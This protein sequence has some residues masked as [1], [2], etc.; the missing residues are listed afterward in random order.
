MAQRVSSAT[1]TASA[2]LCTTLV[3]FATTLVLFADQS[4][5]VVAPAL[6]K[7]AGIPNPVGN[8]PAAIDAGKAMFNEV[9]SDCHG[10]DAVGDK[11]GP[12]LDTGGF[13]H[14]GDD[15]EIFRTIRTGVEGT[16]MEAH[17]EYSDEQTWQLVAYIKSLS[18]GS[19][20]RTFTQRY[21]LGCH[22]DRA[23]RG[24][25]T[26]QGLKLTD[27]PAHGHVWEKVLRQVQAGDM[28]P[29]RARVRPDPEAANRFASF[30]ESTLDRE[31]VARPNPGRVPAHR[32]NRAEYS[33]GI[34]D[35]LAL[36]VKPGEWLPVDDSGYG[37][38]NIAAV[39][40]T[41]PALLERYMSAARRISRMAIG[42]LTLRPAE[43]I[44]EARDGGGNRNEQ[45]NGDLPF[46]SRGGMTV[47]H[48]FPVDAEY[49]FA[50]RFNTDPNA[51]ADAYSVKT[52]L[53][54]GL[55]VVGATTRR[56]HLK[57]EAEAPAGRGPFGGGPPGGGPRE[58]RP[59][60]DLYI[61]RARVHRFEVSG[62]TSDPRQLLIRGPFNI[63]SHG[64]TPSRAQIFM[65][66]PTMAV[67]EVPCARRIVSS[68][69]RRAFRRPVT[70]ADVA[71]L[72]AFYQAARRSGDFDSGIE[73][74]L[75]AML[76]SPEFL[77]RI[78]RA[79][80]RGTAGRVAR[81]SD[82]DLASR[83]SFFL[84]SSI[85]DDEL[86]TLAERGRLKHPAVLKRQ[87]RRML[88][89]RRSEALVKNFAGQ[90]LQIRSVETV[91]PDPGIF[92]F[93][94]TLRRSFIEET[95]L[96]VDSVVRENRSLLDLLDADYTFLNQRLAEHY[97]VPKIYGSQFR[98]V[99]V[100]DANR[101]G[102]LGHG[103]VLTVTSYPN[104]TS[105]VQRG[106]WVLESLLG[107]PPPPPPPDVPD[108]KAAPN[109]KLLSLREQME[110]HRKN[111]VCASCHSRMDPL[112]FSLEN[113]DG[114]GRWR[115]EDAGARIDASGKLPD[116]TTFEGPAGLRQ[117]L[118]TKYRN[119]VVNTAT[120]KLLT[121]ALGRG[122]ESYDHPTVRAIA[123]DASKD[124]YRIASLVT[125]VVQSAPFQMRRVSEP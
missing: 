19:H 8:G 98:R 64:N 31:A 67:D 91:R 48:Y 22:N 125:A 24:G 69:A 5:P 13:M 72:L 112:G 37:F 29:A 42:D 39:L 51:G 45:L 110:V 43:E 27:V 23:K 41:S 84:W 124:N 1:I 116:G 63:K 101:R 120:E 108:L 76:V 59:A 96:L 89:D 100:S 47:E 102:I 111:P 62:G 122:L 109:G 57:A 58:A 77:F 32:L 17:P 85:P 54:A 28:P 30:L 79:P 49:E 55:H 2:A 14:G 88:A 75:R 12:A 6:I 15:G 46:A 97:G 53:P 95:T 34:R 40:T 33:N 9:C 60:V 83:L 16:E 56:E 70:T 115:T 52:F 121:Y 90:W 71:P 7:P 99:P 94:E 82:I 105:V 117:L 26:L 36:D 114:V 21:C 80:A 3:L 18:G 86:L 107:T 113:F 11:D 38:D 103:S 104:R 118:L 50:L 78:E 93:D 119:D 66:R 44:Y 74:A 68:L 106:R 61:D 123:R 73:A 35:L 20:D 10:M 25:L 81:I 65:C 87:V 4:G 92:S